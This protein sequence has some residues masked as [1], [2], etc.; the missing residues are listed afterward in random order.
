MSFGGL[1]MVGQANVPQ[2]PNETVEERQHYPPRAEKLR[3]PVGR[4]TACLLEPK[5]GNMLAVWKM[6]SLQL[7]DI[8]SKNYRSQVFFGVWLYDIFEDETMCH[9]YFS[10]G[11]Y[12]SRT[13]HFSDFAVPG[14]SVARGTRSIRMPS[15]CGTMCVTWRIA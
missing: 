12:G 9:S 2:D 7:A 15:K 3:F 14:H 5:H 1:G 4:A 10:L 8:C 13:S 11:L 6:K